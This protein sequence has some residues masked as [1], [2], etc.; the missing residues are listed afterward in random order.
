MKP[1]DSVL[2]ITMRTKMGL[3]PPAYTHPNQPTT[4]HLR[5]K[6]EDTAG[7]RRIS[8]E[9]TRGPYCCCC[10]WYPAAVPPAAVLPVVLAAAGGVMGAERAEGNSSW[11]VFHS[12]VLMVSS[13]LGGSGTGEQGEAEIPVRNG[14]RN[15]NLKVRAQ[16][17]TGDVLIQ[18]GFHPA[19]AVHPEQAVPARSAWPSNAGPA[20]PNVV[21]AAGQGRWAP[22]PNFTHAIIYLGGRDPW[23]P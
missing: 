14:G 8:P 1:E 20:S 9:T 16:R 22:D 13:N 5:L 19:H 7:R 11:I 17:W 10:P 2:E 12:V 15:S 21:I 4:T 18:T 3:V 23:V 6:P